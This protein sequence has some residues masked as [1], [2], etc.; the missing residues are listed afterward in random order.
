M[1]LLVLYSRLCSVLGDIAVK[2]MVEVC[3][4]SSHVKSASSF[5]LLSPQPMLLVHPCYSLIVPSQDARP[6]CK[7]LLR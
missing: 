4:V 6:Y 7:L 2:D 5:Y 1:R 3:L